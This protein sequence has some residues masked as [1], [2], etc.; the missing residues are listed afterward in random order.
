MAECAY[1][2]KRYSMKILTIL[3]VAL[4]L[5]ACSSDEDLADNGKVDA[6]IWKS[7]TDMLNKARDIEDLLQDAAS[8]RQSEINQ[9]AE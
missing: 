4:L 2:G 1:S 5:S 3:S 9:Q 7:Q 8:A 6:H